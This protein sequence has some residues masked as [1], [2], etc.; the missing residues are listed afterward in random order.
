MNEAKRYLLDTN[1]L[2]LLVHAGDL[3]K[4]VDRQYQLRAQP[5]RP[6]ISVVTVGEALKL[7]MGFGWGLRKR[8]GL[9]RLL[10]EF[11]WVDINREAVLEAYAEIAHFCE[12]NGITVPQND[13]W[14][15]ATAQT[16]QSILLTT[17]RHFDALHGKFLDRIWIDETAAR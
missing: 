3:A 17:D 4:S 8:E 2:V 6:L 1:I 11:V 14:I 7:A 9:T 16:T 13:Y 10:K 15:A 12:S 5:F